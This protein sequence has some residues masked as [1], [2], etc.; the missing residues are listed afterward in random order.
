MTHRLTGALLITCA[1]LLSAPAWACS[2]S[3]P[4]VWSKVWPLPDD[5]LG[6]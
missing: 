3:S 4:G 2:W 6:A 1:C 5:D